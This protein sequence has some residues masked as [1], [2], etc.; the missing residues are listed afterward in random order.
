MK[1]SFL[2]VLVFAL[3]CTARD[4][5]PGA[6]GGGTLVIS[7]GGDPNSLLPPLVE[8]TQGRQVSDLVYDRLAV[9][10]DSLNTLG[11]GGCIPQLAQS[12]TWSRD[13]LSIALHLN[14]KA[15]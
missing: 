11:D 15:K 10:G 3:G 2:A 1:A 13:S 9:I 7:T 5:S 12:W 4:T 14:P 8:S 6:G